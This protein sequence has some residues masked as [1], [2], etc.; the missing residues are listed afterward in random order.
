VATAADIALLKTRRTTILTE[1]S[2]LASKPD[3]N[4]DGQSVQWSATRKA[5]LDEL[6]SIEEL[7]R[8]YSSPFMVVSYGRA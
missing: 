7:L 3:Y 1:L 4:I 6:K 8:M 5:L 2:V